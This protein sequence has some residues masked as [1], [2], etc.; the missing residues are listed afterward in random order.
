[1]ASVV[2]LGLHEPTALP[3]LVDEG[4]L[5]PDAPRNTYTWQVVSNEDDEEIGDDELLITRSCVVWSRGGL[6]RKSFRFEVEEEPITQALLTYFNRDQDTHPSIGNVLSR[7]K[8]KPRDKQK[9]G[10]LPNLRSKALVIFLKTQAHVYFLSG[11]SHV[12]HLPF[13]VE[14]VVAAPNGLILQRKLRAPSSVPSSFKL[15]RVP[16]NSFVSSLAQ[17]WSA[18]SSQQSTFSIADLGSPQQL[19]SLTLPLLGDLWELPKERSDASWPRLFSLTDPLME[20]GLVV[21]DATAPVESFTTSHKKGQHNNNSLSPSEEILFVSGLDDLAHNSQ[22]EPELPMLCVTF[23]RDVGMYTV[24]RFTY[25]ESEMTSHDNGN[26]PSRRK[27]RRSS[28]APGGGT[29]ATTPAAAGQLSLRE[30]LGGNGAVLGARSSQIQEELDPK[31]HFESSLD[32]DFEAV[33]VPKRQSRRVSSMLARADLSFSNEHSAFTE[34]ATGHQNVTA[35][36]GHSIGNQHNRNS[37]G[38]AVSNGQT[39]FSTVQLNS[40]L[41]APVDSLLEELKAGGD[42]EGF[43]SMGLEDDEFEGLR[44]EIVLTKINSVPAEHSSVRFSSRHRTASS[45]CKIFMLSA[46]NGISEDYVK[47]AFVICILDPSEKKLLIMA[48][49]TQKHPKSRNTKKKPNERVISVLWGNDRRADGVLDACKLSDGD[50]SRILVLTETADGFGELTLQAPWTTLIKVSLP[51]KLTVHH[52]RSLGNDVSST[53]RRRENG[54]KRVLTQGPRA[55]IGLQN[56]KAQ[57]IVDL[58]DD[59]GRLHQLQITMRPRNPQV[60]KVLSVCQFILPG[61]SGGEGIMVGWCNVRQ[62]L[63]Q[64]S[65]DV[66]DA[67]Y[68]AL[69][70]MLFAMTLS[71]CSPTSRKKLPLQQRNSHNRLNRSS[72]SSLADTECW[73]AMMSQEA[74][75]GGLKSRWIQSNGW[76]WISCEEDSPIPSSKN[77]IMLRHVGLAR[78]FL[79]SAIGQIAFSSDGYLPTGSGKPLERQQAALS[80]IL[81][82]LHLLHEEQKLYIT[83]VDSV[84]LG[85]TPIIAQMCKWLGWHDWSTAYDVEGDEMDGNALDN[86]MFKFR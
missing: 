51:G 67:E 31:V 42:F 65:I 54:L 61:I 84:S 68:S 4:L 83:L 24:W 76:S 6:V 39:S 20:L 71:L 36:R 30:S 33:G 40:H 8:E 17:P 58:L 50:M 9:Q 26:Q 74:K 62:W 29:G 59:E 78:D 12:I 46:P 69:V 53:S 5:Q 45:Q 41:E 14:S 44:K 77:N 32:P 82:S 10:R 38:G 28:F 55:L 86:G 27:S 66:L 63:K 70:I 22:T 80:D 81:L 3:Y 49:N 85:L 43:H 19:P 2:S 64:E 60:A 18:K 56:P 75:F 16:P 57:G 73:V 72:N 23:N 37:L 25:T 35:R 79:A 11:S 15:P 21:A 7:S 52:F 13:E 34:L 47:D 1:M 48:L